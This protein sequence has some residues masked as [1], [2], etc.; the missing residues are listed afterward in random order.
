MGMT[1]DEIRAA[2][3]DLEQDHGRNARAQEIARTRERGAWDCFDGHTVAEK[4][5]LIQ[6]VGDLFKV[7]AVVDA[8]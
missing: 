1:E 2:K 5:L 4:T 7:A 6:R 3:F 8:F